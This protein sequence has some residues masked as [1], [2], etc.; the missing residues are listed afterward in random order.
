MISTSGDDIEMGRYDKLSSN[1]KLTSDINCVYH[2]SVCLSQ[3]KK[4][5]SKNGTPCFTIG[6]GGDYFLI[7]FGN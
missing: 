5:E 3:K 6:S 7:F 2:V 1:N 4:T